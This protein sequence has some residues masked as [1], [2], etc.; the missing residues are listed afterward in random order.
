LLT[1]NQI[2]VLYMVGSVIC[3]S[4]MDICVKWLDYY[5]V[6]QVLFLRFFIGFIPIIFIIPK[7]K[8]FSFYKTSRPGLH[9]FRAI[10]GAVAIIALFLGLRE[11]PLADVVSLTFGG[12]IFVTI[13]SIF[14]LSEKVGI[15]R[16]SAVFL[17]FL[18]M[19]LIVQPA[20]IDVNY[21]YITPIVFCIFFACVAI[22]VRSL[23]KT[24][25]NYT[26]A[27]YFTLLCTL[28]G[29]ATI[30]FTDW[31]MPNLIDFVLFFVLGLCGSV[32]NLLLT[33]SYRLAEASLVTPIKY[34]S[35]V[36]AIIF[37]YFI[38]SEVPKILTLFGAS[39]VIASSLI[40]FMREN[41]LKKQIVA[42]RT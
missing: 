11:L 14:F 25:A 3:F 24:E 30:F 20:F 42:P 40:I 41:K 19:L 26:I 28:L 17:G 34:L 36:F 23:S 33:Q 2:G 1:Q 27:F 13:A 21:Y 38:W 22:S 4:I 31:I 6:G 15:K 32:A 16:W 39:L 9:A 10:S 8:I 12:P 18:G 37:G 29:L 7:D 35:L 5:P